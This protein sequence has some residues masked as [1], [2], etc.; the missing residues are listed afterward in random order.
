MNRLATRLAR[1][2]VRAPRA[3]WEHSR[4]DGQ[5]LA[6]PERTAQV[7]QILVEAGALRITAGSDLLTRTNDGRWTPYTPR[8]G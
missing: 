8:S 7:A 6:T 2:E 1:L 3:V 4:A 5:A